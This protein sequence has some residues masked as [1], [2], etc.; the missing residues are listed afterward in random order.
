MWEEAKGKGTLAF[1]V[2]QQFVRASLD[3]MEDEAWTMALSCELSRQLSSSA[4]SSGEKTFLY[5][6]LGTV[7]GACKEVLHVQEK[8]LQHLEGANAEE[9]S[10]AQSMHFSEQMLKKMYLLSRRKIFKDSSLRFDSPVHLSNT[11]WLGLEKQVKS[12]GR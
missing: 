6:A 11:V 3:I 10:E 9:P 1:P 7:L 5:K 12:E 8:L 2:L 4:S